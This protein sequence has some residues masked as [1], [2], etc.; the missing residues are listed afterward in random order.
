MKR[1]KEDGFFN[2]IGGL[3]E[4]LPYGLAELPRDEKTIKQGMADEVIENPVFSVLSDEPRFKSLSE[5][6]INNID[7]G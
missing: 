4:L 7:C 2:L 6:L 1:I 3:T 5:K